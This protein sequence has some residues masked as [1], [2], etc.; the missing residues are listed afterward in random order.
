M[1][2][3]ADFFAHLGY[4]HGFGRSLPPKE[5]IQNNPE[6]AKVLETAVVRHNIVGVLELGKGLDLAYKRGW[7]QAELIMTPDE[8]THYIFPTEVHRL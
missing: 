7:L 1:I 4:N 8:Q 5:V 3:A 2:K 6:V